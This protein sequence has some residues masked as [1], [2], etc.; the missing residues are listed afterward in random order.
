MLVV[1][2]VVNI[3]IQL[4]TVGGHCLWV[5]SPRHQP[6]HVITVQGLRNEIGVGCEVKVALVKKVAKR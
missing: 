4:R 1:S 6:V 5:G 3:V 2:L